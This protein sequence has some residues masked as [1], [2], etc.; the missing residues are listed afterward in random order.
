MDSLSLSL[1]LCLV[2]LTPLPSSARQTLNQGSS[3]SAENPDDVIVSPE[4]TFTAGFYPLGTNAYA[5]AIWFSQPTCFLGHNCTLVW[6][7]NRDH[8]VN[9]RRSKLL[10]ENTGD[11]VL[12]DAAQFNVWTTGTATESKLTTYLQLAESG[13]LFLRDSEGTILWQ[14]FDSPTDTLLPQQPLSRLT[15]LVSSRGKG[16]YSSGFYRFFFDYDNVL[17]I[18]FDGHET[19]SDYWPYPWLSSWDADRSTYNSS[20]LAMINLFGNFSSSDN[21]NFRSADYGRSRIQRRLSLDYDGNLRMYS[22][23]RNETWV[24]SW[25]A[26]S[27]P[28]RIHGI[29]GE[30]S[31]CSYA[32]NTGRICS[33]LEGYKQRDPSDWSY[34]CEPEFNVLPD[35]T[36][37]TF[38]HLRHVEFF[39]D[40]FRLFSNKTIKECEAE[41]LQRVNC[42]GFQHNFRNHNGFQFHDCYPKAQLRN[43][44][45]TSSFD[46]DFYVKVPK[47]YNTS[48]KKTEHLQRTLDCPQNNTIL[49]K[50]SYVKS[51]ENEIVKFMLWFACAL[52]GLEFISI[53][54]VWLFFYR[55]SHDKNASRDGYVFAATG[56]KRFTF[57][58]LKKA[59]RNFHE[60]IGRGGGGTVYKGTLSDGRVIAVKR[61]NDSNQ[62]EAEFLAEVNTIGKLN[63]MNLIEMWGFCADKKN[64]L[65]V[66]EYMEHGSLADM[67]S[68][69][70]NE[71]DWQKKYDIALG[72]ARG[73]AYLHDECLEWELHCDV[74]P[75]NILLDTAYNPKVSDFGL[76]KL[77]DRGK[78]Y[79][80]SFSK[81]RGTRGYMAP[82]WVLNQPITSKVDVY[83]YG[84]VVLEM[85]TGQSSIRGIQLVDRADEE[86]MSKSNHEKQKMEVLVRVALDCVQEDRDARPTMTQVVERLLD[87]S[88]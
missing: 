55:A 45:Q 18:L 88:Q 80:S 26:I 69:A 42:K 47:S 72:T 41:C 85:V 49:L 51:Q 84:I 3:L 79:N 28:C 23:E 10:L 31:L 19:S 38:I 22:R 25:Q 17:R 6:M 7:A 34:G 43:G 65:L 29:C 30:N 39:G 70:S 21:L 56:F 1:I 13:N 52:G 54:L 35:S 9:G 16:N 12:T 37:F 14:S 40:D 53:F 76:S 71:L 4:G 61:L 15:Q 62:G 8:P 66:Y 63:H 48:D 73:L 32:P 67:L 58:E 36:D 60:E 77:L 50:R 24:V 87:S 57:D 86:P 81:I 27:Q 11:L 33:C 83:S 64:R 20:R 74:K 82:E 44:Q 59:T 75:Q 78:L 5:F 46:G 68:S 2:L